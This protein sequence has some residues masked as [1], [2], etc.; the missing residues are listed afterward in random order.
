M[1]EANDAREGAARSWTDSIDDLRWDVFYD[2]LLER[3]HVG[4]REQ[5][6]AI[7]AED[8]RQVDLEKLD[9]AILAIVNAR[10]DSSN[11]LAK[12]VR[13]Q[14]DE[15]IDRIVEMS[16]DMKDGLTVLI[17]QEALDSILGA[18]AAKL[19]ATEKRAIDHTLTEVLKAKST[20]DKAFKT[21]IPASSSVLVTLVVYL[22]A[23]Y[24]QVWEDTSNWR[25]I[26]R[27]IVATNNALESS[28]ADPP[29][30]D[31]TTVTIVGWV[32][33]LIF[34]IDRAM[35]VESG[36]NCSCPVTMQTAAEEAAARAA[37][38]LSE[39]VPSPG[40]SRD[41][42]LSQ[43]KE[44]L[45]GYSLGLRGG[46]KEFVC[47]RAAIDLIYFNSISA[48]SEA[49]G[50]YIDGG[51]DVFTNLAEVIEETG[52]N[53]ELLGNDVYASELRS[54]RLGLEGL[55]EARNRL[56]VDL[57]NVI[58][59]YPFAVGSDPEA[60]VEAAAKCKGGEHQWVFAGHTASFEDFELTDMWDGPAVQ[61]F[62]G[63]S[64]S[65]ARDVQVQTR[66]E[67]ILEFS[68]DLTFSIEIRISSLGNHY[69]RM[70][71]RLNDASVHDLNQAMR[72]AT[73]QMGDE[74]V[75][76]GPLDSRRQEKQPEWQRLTDLAEELIDS[77]VNHLEPGKKA[78]PRKGQPHIIV[79][80]RKVSIER[81]VSDQSDRFRRDISV[82]DLSKAKG[83]ALLV[84]PVRQAAAVLEEWCRYSPPDFNDEATIRPLSFVGDFAH[85]TTNT[86]C[87]LLRGIPEYLLMEH[88]EAAEFVASLPVLLENWMGQILDRAHTADMSHRSSADLLN[89][90]QLELRELLSK[91]TRVIAEI[92]SP[93]LCLTA[94]HREYLDEMFA[95]AGIER[96][97]RELQ[98][99][100]AVLD[101]HF[102]M[103]ATMA[104]RKEQKDLEVQQFFFG[105]G[106]VLVGVP[107]L[108]ALFGL[109]DAGFSVNRTGDTIEALI[110]SI[111]IVLLFFGVFRLPGAKYVLDSIHSWLKRK[112]GAFKK[113][114]FGPRSKP[115]VKA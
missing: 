26:R 38:V 64:V 1:A 75:T 58:Y 29:H 112:V 104:A 27:A 45:R 94:V 22:Y 30:C 16:I 86:T 74:R 10:V 40:W 41:D 57:A 48:V 73:R 14:V 31:P 62:T 54:H 2:D 56:H 4:L 106:A 91:A 99:H 15:E 72:R 35:E 11:N 28:K 24:L 93:E 108:A 36:L 32:M 79:T 8:P 110:L 21:A 39:V 82:E 89:Q 33:R 34:V 69:V 66:A 100:F 52:S 6:R 84:Q 80:A 25:G 61:R 50:N 18:A 37:S 113:W 109:F 78:P 23:K 9:E 111:L 59:C 77:V 43:A 70:Q 87:G 76:F 19:S 51:S 47:S 107:S 55:L 96:L 53:E 60:L 42:L 101:A 17:K 68:D 71:R 5:L 95:I 114:M 20:L 44:S 115:K 85:R 65:F 49:V 7:Q 63:I 67:E 90:R 98:S 3:K 105:T 83:A 46:C 13:D 97:E 81:V 102:Q 12:A 88:E 103:L 92:H